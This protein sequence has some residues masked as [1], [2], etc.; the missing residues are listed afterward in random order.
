MN[1]EVRTL[2]STPMPIERIIPAIPGMVSVK[3]STPPNRPLVQASIPA[4][5][6]RRA[7]EATNP[8]TRY[9][10]IIMITMAAKAIIP[11]SSIT[12]REASPRVGLITRMVS[13]MVRAKGSEPALILSARAL[14]SSAFCIPVMMALPFVITE[15]T[16]GAEMH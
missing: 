5:C 3:L 9:F 4:I 16:L 6:P 1:S 15:L 14:D 7:M 2:A 8:G 10:K 11:A 12:L 13:S